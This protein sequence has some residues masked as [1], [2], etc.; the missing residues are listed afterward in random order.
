MDERLY[1]LMHKASTMSD[2]VKRWMTGE[3]EPLFLSNALLQQ[4]IHGHI[5]YPDIISGVLDCVANMALLTLRKVLRS[6]CHARQRWSTLPEQTGQPPLV[7]SELLD[8]AG[9]I[10][11][12]RRRAIIAFDFVRENSYLAAKPLE[13]GLRQVDSSGF[14]F[15]VSAR[16]E[17]EGYVGLGNGGSW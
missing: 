11:Q 16:H 7:S 5:E 12:R 17:R 10:E 6:L 1:S 8:D 3:A 9:T 13:F 14:S 2:D 15:S 4:N